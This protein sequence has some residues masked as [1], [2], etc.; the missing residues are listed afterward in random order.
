MSSYD[1]T[2]KIQILGGMYSADNTNFFGF[3]D[4]SDYTISLL[5]DSCERSAP[6]VEYNRLT[7][8]F[9]MVFLE[10][11]DFKNNVLCKRILSNIVRQC[12]WV[13]FDFCKVAR[14]K[15]KLL[16]I[17][18]YEI[19]E[20]IDSELTRF[21]ANLKEPVPEFTFDCLMQVCEIAKEKEL[22]VGFEK[23]V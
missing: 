13:D 16:D 10:N 14:A 6:T 12:F 7:F 2:N 4:C 22:C 18:S 3:I 8:K 19:D 17:K 1:T 5:I 21:L 15:L 20:V 23:G 11:S 9:F